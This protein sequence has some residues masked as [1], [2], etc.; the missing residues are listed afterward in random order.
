MAVFAWTS[1]THSRAAPTSKTHRHSFAIEMKTVAYNPTDHQVRSPKEKVLITAKMGLA[2]LQCRKPSN[3]I[4][5][6][7]HECT[8]EPGIRIPFGPTTVESNAARLVWEIP[9]RLTGEDLGVGSSPITSHATT[10][11][12]LSEN[13]QDTRRNTVTTVLPADVENAYALDL[14]GTDRE[15]LFKNAITTC[16]SL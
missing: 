12:A 9:E 5:A 1:H 2:Q 15:A 8:T 10:D 16:A 14:N 11:H 13:R 6:T 7:I 4:D 3:A